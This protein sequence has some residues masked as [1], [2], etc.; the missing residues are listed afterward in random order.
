MRLI[1]DPS[2][3]DW[4]ILTDDE[5]S[6]WIESNWVEDDISAC[7]LP[8]PIYCEGRHPRWSVGLFRAWHA[9]LGSQ[10]L[11]QSE[12]A[13]WKHVSFKPE[14]APARRKTNNPFNVIIRPRVKSKPRNLHE[15]FALLMSR[16]EPEPPSLPDFAILSVAD[17]VREMN[18]YSRD[19]LIRAVSAGFF[20]LPFTSCYDR[21]WASQLSDWPALWTMGQIRE[22]ETWR[23]RFGLPDL[24]QR[25]AASVPQDCDDDWPPEILACLETRFRW[26]AYPEEKPPGKRSSCSTF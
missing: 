11:I 25:T 23:K 18:L 19:M 14:A 10:A 7:R 3:P 9:F 12:K 13:G 8:Q 24:P 16:P 17:V 20:V 4:R 15:E 21:A 2:V 22:W 6:R 26:H 1:S 5:V